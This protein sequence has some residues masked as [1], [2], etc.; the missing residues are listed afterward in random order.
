MCSLFYHFYLCQ[1]MILA[2]IVILMMISIFGLRRLFESILLI[3]NHRGLSLSEE[4]G[5]IIF[6]SIFMIIVKLC[7]SLPKSSSSLEFIY[8]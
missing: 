8:L 6:I 7:M 3:K 5:L 1:C 2:L 4:I